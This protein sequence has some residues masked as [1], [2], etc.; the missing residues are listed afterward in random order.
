LIDTLESVVAEIEAA[1]HS[2]AALTLYALVSTLEHERAG[3]LFKL[4][5][6]RDLDPAQRQLAFAL[7][8]LMAERGNQGADWDAAK[9]RMDR[10]VRAG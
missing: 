10:L 4:D 1:P 5:K 2:A 9:A 6:L 7:L 8:E 3:Y